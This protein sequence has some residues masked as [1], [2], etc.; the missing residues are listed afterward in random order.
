MINSNVLKKMGIKN[1]EKELSW[2]FSIDIPF[3]G[4]QKFSLVPLIGMKKMRWKER[5]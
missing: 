3:L 2:L 5:T 1:A 4:Y